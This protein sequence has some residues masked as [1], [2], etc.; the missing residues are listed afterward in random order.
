[1]TT[2]ERAEEMKMSERLVRGTRVIS[3][4]DAKDRRGA[5]NTMV[6]I[7]ERHGAREIVLPNIGYASF[8][9]GKLNPDLRMYRF[10]DRGDR[11]LCLMPEYT[12]LLAAMEWEPDTI[13]WYCERCYRYDR[14]QKGRYRE[15]TQFGVELLNPSR[16]EAYSLI[17]RIALEI[18]KGLGLSEVTRMIHNASRGASYYNDGKGFEIECPSLGSQKQL[19]GGGPYKGGAGFAIGVDRAVLARTCHG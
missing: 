4:E 19:V 12:N 6:C 17:P 9:D 3:G 14:P 16:A 5:I 1:M 11:E 7:A 8:F 15:F 13:V 2:V 10:K 18:V